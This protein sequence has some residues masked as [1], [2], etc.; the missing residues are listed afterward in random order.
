MRSAR[1]DIL[2]EPLQIGTK[3]FRNRFYSV[4]HA[5]FH[6]G[7][8]LSDIAFRRMK[9][10]GG[11]AA[12][13]GGVISLRA[14]SWGG[15]VPRI[16][17]DE[18]RAVLARVAVEVQSQGAL[19]GLELGHGG[20]RGE[21][22][23]FEPALGPSPIGDPERA[24][25][26]PK[27][28]DLD[29]IRRLQ[30]DW[31]AAAVAAAD[32][33]Y[34]IVYAYGAHGYLPAQF[35]SPYFNRRTDAYGGSLE[36]R[37]R[38]WLEMIE[39]FRSEIG[40]RC[41][42]AARIAAE[43]FTRVG[44]SSADTL[45]F[46]RMAD[47]FVDLWDV[48]VGH[49]WGRDSAAWRVAPEGYQV[50]WSGKVRSATSKPIVGVSR[51]TTPDAMAE[52][53]RSG[54]WDMIGGARPGIADPFL[55]RK[56]EEGRYDD[57]RECTGGNFC[58]SVETTGHGLS[59][60]QNSTIGEEYRRGWHPERFTP[61]R[62]R[63]LNVLVVGAGPAGMECARVLGER[64]VQ[65]VHLVDAAD[66]IGGHVNWLRA[67][68]GEGGFGRV[69]DYRTTQLA[70]LPNVSTVPKTRLGIEDVIDYGADVV[71][72]ATGSHWIGLDSDLHGLPLRDFENN[73]LSIVTP[74]AIM[75]DGRRPGGRVVVWDSDG[76]AIG[77]G[78]AEK[79]AADGADVT[80]VTHFDVIAPVL[81]LTFEGWVARRRLHELGV[82][83]RSGL[84]PRRYTAGALVTVDQFHDEAVFEAETM[85]VVTQR[86]SDDG[87]YRGLRDRL[88]DAR[89]A[90]VREVW[91]IGDCVA[92]RALGLTLA[93][94]HRLGREIDSARP[95]IP[96][97]PRTE[98]D[99]HA[100]T[101]S[102]GYDVS[103]TNGIAIPGDTHA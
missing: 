81:D 12:V 76:G 70:K 54:V 29:D 66:S 74:E 40:D 73:G 6:P 96:L 68:P 34:D 72:I 39:R 5:S 31:V 58:I 24:R 65:S 44:V 7:R 16:W 79:L 99:A 48:N 15:F 78:L 55:P 23:K 27:E 17:D 80:L 10:E 45:D 43:N 94:G 77:V 103:D 28:M 36:N 90:G 56:I 95:G 37:G 49:V 92:P 88:D 14:D 83:M 61:I 93:D 51:L 98:R 26:V 35:L 62:D 100:T 20:G 71:V 38:F 84:T 89:E 8:R 11:W 32:L 53:L 60:V 4:P 82:A 97:A 64:Q 101:A 69:V 9:A 75:V 102:F 13:C 52:I 87:L 30:D 41:L 33:G 21:G 67:L 19:A 2:F 22:A 18:D 25:W 85:V 42:V 47:E 3:I 63:S 46:V 50:E 1:H 59:C 86:V 57:I 91:R